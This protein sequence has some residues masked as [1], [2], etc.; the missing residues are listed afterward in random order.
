MG[1]ELVDKPADAL[2]G[3]VGDLEVARK[4]MHMHTGT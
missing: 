1:T 2:C 3:V 4:I